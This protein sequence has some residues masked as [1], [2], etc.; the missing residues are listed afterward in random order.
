MGTRETLVRGA[1]A[2]ALL[3]TASFRLDRWQ[4]P[5]VALLLFA[6][7]AVDTFRAPAP[8]RT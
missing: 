6:M 7:L 3:Q 2:I 4:I 1:A 5:V 8:R